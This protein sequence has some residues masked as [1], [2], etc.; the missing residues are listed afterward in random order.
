MQTLRQIGLTSGMALTLALLVPDCGYAQ[1]VEH[2]IT[3][4]ESIEELIRA[5]GSPQQVLVPE[6]IPQEAQTGD[7][8]EVG[9]TGVKTNTAVPPPP[10][11]ISIST[12]T[13]AFDSANLTP[14]AKRRLNR[15]GAALSAPEV[16]NK[17]FLVEGHTDAKGTWEYNMRLSERRAQS[18]YNYLVADLGI[19][20][21]RLKTSGRG[22][23]EL[24]PNVHPNSG[25][26]RRVRFVPFN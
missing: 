14:D 25:E 8:A 15:I 1:P 18:V 5:F 16:T 21:H 24:L 10:V 4:E 3:G 17:R 11:A 19:S 22:K 26:N 6:T 13:F 12:I 2:S 7:G 20:S 23:A 9:A